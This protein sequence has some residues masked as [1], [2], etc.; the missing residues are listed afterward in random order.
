MR[1]KLFSTVAALG[2]SAFATSAGA[3]PVIP[4]GAGFGMDTPAGRGGTIY[5]V[6][7]LNA[8]GSGSLKACIDASGPRVCVFETS[9]TIRLSSDLVINNPRITIA[10]QTAPSPGIMLRGGS[11]RAKASDVLI[12]HIRIRV[13]DDPNGSDPENRDSI[14][15]SNGSS[16]S[17][18]VIDH[19]SFSWSIDEMASVWSGWD[20]VTFS[21]NIFAE[22]L[23]NS[24]HPKGEHGFG[25][26]AS[27]R[28]SSFSFIGNL[29]AHSY[30]RNVLSRAG[31][32]VYVNN[33]VYNR[34]NRDLDLQNQDGVRS[35]NSIVG[36]V[37]LRGPDYAGGSKPVLLRGDSN[38]LLSGTKVY[39]EDNAAVEATGDPW[40][41]VGDSTGLARSTLQASTRPVWPAGLQARKTANDGVLNWVLSN[42]GARPA[43][44][45]SVDER[46]VSHVRNRAGGVVNC[47]Q[48]DGSQRCQRNAGG[49]PNLAVNKRTLDLPSNPNGDSDGDGY[50]NL[51]EFLHAMAAE[52]EGE[53]GGNS[54]DPRPMPPE[55]ILVEGG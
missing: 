21:H 36:N 7:N 38:G 35:M 9:G 5:R 49:W 13:G 43:D 18:V 17:G 39:V 4:G 32:F 15:V 46:I 23:H 54:N 19:C 20:D 42:A 27:A 12:Q 51:E 1:L 50:T 55:I 53:P 28:P 29:I 48:A 34:V 37:F 30:S 47:V 3:L 22:P 16:F 44:R 45:D 10:G 24:L 31:E 6:T 41:V 26:I 2:L 14:A 33:V 8:S 40:S 11:L 52:L 25:I